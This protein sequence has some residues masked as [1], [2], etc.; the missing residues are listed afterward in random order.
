MGIEPTTQVWKTL[1]LPLHQSRTT[2]ATMH[3]LEPRPRVLE[4]RVLPL[5]LHRTWWALLDL[6]QRPSDYE[7]LALTN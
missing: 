4:T 2:L 7:S 6:N 1:M 3:G 5:T